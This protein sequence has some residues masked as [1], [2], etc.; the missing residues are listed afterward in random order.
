MDRDL[1][2]QL[3]ENIVQAI[4]RD[5]LAH[6]LLSLEAVGYRTVFHVHDEVICEVPKSRG[7]Q[8][9]REIQH[10]FAAVPDW[11]E[12]LPLKGAGYTTDYY[13]KD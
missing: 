4:A 10:I 12:G 9:L 5:C 11:A 1:R 13:L 2:W 6:T 3:T 7:D 8:A